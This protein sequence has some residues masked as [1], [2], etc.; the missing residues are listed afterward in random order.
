MTVT[1]SARRALVSFFRGPLRGLEQSDP[2]EAGK[3]SRDELQDCAA[4]ICD[5]EIG[6]KEVKGRASPHHFLRQLVRPF[7]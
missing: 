2:V 7:L 1:Q 6:K 5:Q 4:G 3:G